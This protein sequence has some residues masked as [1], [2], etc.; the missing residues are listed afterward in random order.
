MVLS[1]LSVR[2]ISGEDL[3]LDERRMSGG[4]QRDQGP[5]VR[6]RVAE[7]QMPST[8]GAH[9]SPSLQT[10]KEEVVTLLQSYPEGI[11][12][13]RL[14]LLYRRLYGRRFGPLSSYGLS[15]LQELFLQIGDQ[16]CVERTHSKNMI[17]AVNP[18]LRGQGMN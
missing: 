7:E 18:G 3:V 15:G 10:L 13:S 9:Q 17:R 4:P 16:V 12:V 6:S 8:S 1:E 11:E 14:T 2:F 5:P